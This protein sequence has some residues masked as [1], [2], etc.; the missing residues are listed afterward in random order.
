MPWAPLVVCLPKN[1]Q[2]NSKTNHKRQPSKSWLISKEGVTLRIFVVS[3]FHEV[4]THNAV[5]EREMNGPSQY[6]FAFPSTEKYPASTENFWL[7]VP[8]MPWPTLLVPIASCQLLWICLPTN[9]ESQRRVPQIKGQQGTPRHCRH[10]PLGRFSML[11]FLQIVGWKEREEGKEE[12][13]REK[14]VQMSNPW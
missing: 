4:S 8:S 7:P 1:K 2:I 5:R 13:E 11:Q 6:L 9:M 14:K 3:S 10:Q 12:G